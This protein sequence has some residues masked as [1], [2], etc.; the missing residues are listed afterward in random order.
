MGGCDRIPGILFFGLLLSWHSSLV[1]HFGQTITVLPVA[2]WGQQGPDTLHL[3][4]FDRRTLMKLFMMLCW[5]PNI[6][7][8]LNFCLPWPES[9]F[10]WCWINFRH[11]L[12]FTIRFAECVLVGFVGFTNLPVYLRM[13]KWVYIIWVSCWNFLDIASSRFAELQKDCSAHNARRVLMIVNKAS[14]KIAY[15]RCFWKGWDPVHLVLHIDV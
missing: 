11:T 3:S 6:Y 2:H 15:W 13:F 14:H 1:F 5:L 9:S 12:S 8:C 10:G 4:K 7:H